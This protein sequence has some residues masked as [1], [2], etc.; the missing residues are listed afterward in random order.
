MTAGFIRWFPFSNGKCRRSKSSEKNIFWAP[1]LFC[2]NRRHKT[3]PPRAD[4]IWQPA[5]WGIK[6]RK[7]FMAAILEKPFLLERERGGR[8]RKGQHCSVPLPRLASISLQFPVGRQRCRSST[9]VALPFYEQKFSPD[10]P[11]VSC[12]CVFWK[13]D[14][15]SKFRFFYNRN[16]RPR[17]CVL[18]SAL[19]V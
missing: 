9:F 12:V 16:H 18:K 6:E 13:A 14:A 11:V 10:R 17:L 19:N 15:A 2:P 3:P 1:P 7:R 5:G 4:W 8:E